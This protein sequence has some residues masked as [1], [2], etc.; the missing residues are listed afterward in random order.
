MQFAVA[1]DHRQQ[2]LFVE[3]INFI[4]QQKN[5]SAG[6]LD[7]FKDLFIGGAKAVGGVDQ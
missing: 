3:S 2:A 4:Q 6:A 1:L 5:R 7:Q